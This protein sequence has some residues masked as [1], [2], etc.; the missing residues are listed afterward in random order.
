M[1]ALVSLAAAKR[2]CNLAADFTLDD[3]YIQELI[4]AAS[5]E[6]INYLKGRADRFLDSSGGFAT[7]TSITDPPDFAPIG[8]AVLVYVAIMYKDREGE[9]HKSGN[10]LP[11]PVQAKLF[12]LRK[13]ALG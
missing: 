6:V 10:Y 4:E 5:G 9:S 1:V 7:D 12:P 3:T 2:H 13:P 11:D 8:Q